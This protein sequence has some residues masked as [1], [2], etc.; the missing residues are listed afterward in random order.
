MGTAHHLGFRHYLFNKYLH[1][2]TYWRSR[3]DLGASP[4]ENRHSEELALDLEKFDN[5]LDRF[6]CIDIHP[7]NRT[8]PDP[9]LANKERII[10][11]KIRHPTKLKLPI[12]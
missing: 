9:V 1:P 8:S 6:P 5:N 11:P 2:P 4:R 10:E 7:L 3:H 12:R